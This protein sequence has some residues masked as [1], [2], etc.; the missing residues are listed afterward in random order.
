MEHKGKA[1]TVE[2]QTD[3]Y[4]AGDYVTFEVGDWN[5][6][7]YS[8]HA[9]GGGVLSFLVVEA[10]D[11]QLVAIPASAGVDYRMDGDRS[12]EVEITRDGFINGLEGSRNHRVKSEGKVS[13]GRSGYHKVHAGIEKT[14][15]Q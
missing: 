15:N 13:E 1:E 11:D 9:N 14:R 6:T 4:D 3:E 5:G 8:Y 7:G 2:V 10:F 12:L